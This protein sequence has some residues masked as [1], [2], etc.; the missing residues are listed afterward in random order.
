MEQGQPPDAAGQPQ[1]PPGNHDSLG[2]HILVGADRPRHSEIKYS[3]R[4]RQPPQPALPLEA[5]EPEHVVEADE[6]PLEQQPPPE[7]LPLEQQLLEADDEHVEE[8]ST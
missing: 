1:T 7:E 6:L 8:V 3:R 2:L 4:P 5:V